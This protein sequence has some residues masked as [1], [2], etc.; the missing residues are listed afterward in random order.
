MSDQ[1]PYNSEQY[2]PKKARGFVSSGGFK[3]TILVIIILL[4]LIPITMIRSLVKSA[5][6]A[7][8][9]RK[10]RLWKHGAASLRCTAP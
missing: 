1:I 5:V 10:D 3:I 2:K 6:I 8:K 9:G 4:L 7:R